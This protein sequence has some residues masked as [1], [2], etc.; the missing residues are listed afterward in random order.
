[1]AQLDEQARRPGALESS[2]DETHEQSSRYEAAHRD[3]EAVI[4]HP[5]DV[6]PEGDGQGADHRDHGVH[7]DRKDRREEGAPCRRRGRPPVLPEC[8]R[9]RDREDQIAELAW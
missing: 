9:D 2:L 5:A 4:S 8:D 1:V 3:L 6:E 7:R